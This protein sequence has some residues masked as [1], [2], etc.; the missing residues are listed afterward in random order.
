M[1]KDTLPVDHFEQL[2]AR[3]PD[4]W[5][6][7]T[8]DYERA[9]YAAT[10]AALPRAHYGRGLE[11][12]CANGIFTAALA[13]RCEELLA[14]EPVE[15]ALD[16]ARRY[17]AD[18]PN[19]RFARMFVPAAWPARFFDLIVLSEVI[20]YFGE[21]DIDRLAQRVL[22]SLMSGGDMILVH[23]IGKKSLRPRDEEATDRL[24][25]RLGSDFTMLRAERNTDYRLDLLRRA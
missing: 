24:V 5:H 4:P 23:W 11:V 21:A 8:S 15:T 25:A 16:A 10:L 22:G 2:Y 14:I 20:D 7:A 18:R 6:L 12:G 17:N 1:R 9:K 13:G 3:R 19:V